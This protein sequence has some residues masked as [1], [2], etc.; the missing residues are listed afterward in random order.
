MRLSI[1]QSLSLVLVASVAIG[2]LSRNWRYH[3]AI[4]LA[5]HRALNERTLDI[6]YGEECYLPGWLERILPATISSDFYHITELTFPFD[7][8]SN[9]RSHE[10]QSY[11][12]CQFVRTIQMG[13]LTLP[14]STLN[15]ILGFPRLERI[16]VVPTHATYNGQDAVN[17]LDFQ[18]GTIEI[19]VNP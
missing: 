14:R 11:H 1:K 15:E 8:L 6:E 3:E 13:N 2:V 4:S 16:V 18:S 19:L 17:L 10:V 9:A 12:D 7:D 5:E